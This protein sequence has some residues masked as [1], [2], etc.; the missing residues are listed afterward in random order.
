MTFLVSA[1]KAGLLPLSMASFL[2]SPIFAPSAAAEILFWP[3]RL[4][5]YSGY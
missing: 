4:D 1:V 3:A 2:T 5:S